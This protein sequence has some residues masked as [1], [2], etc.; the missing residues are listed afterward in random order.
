MRGWKA[1]PLWRDEISSLTLATQDTWRAFWDTLQFDPFPVLFPAVLRS[2]HALVGDSDFALRILGTSIGLA[3]IGA[4]WIVA[5]MT[6]RRPP[7][8]ALLLLGSSPTVIIWGDTLR[9]YGLS[10]FWI[11]ISF[12]C[13]WR[14]LAYPSRRTMIYATGASILSVQS[15]FTN[16]VLVFALVAAVSLIALRRRRWNSMIMAVGAGLL[17]AVS[18]LPYLPTILRIRQWSFLNQT[19]VVPATHLRIFLEAINGSGGLTIYLWLAALIAALTAGLW[20]TSAKSPERDTGD[21]GRDL[22]C[23]S[24]LVL[25]LGLITTFLFFL[26]T[27]WEPNVWYFLPVLSLVAVAIDTVASAGAPASRA[28]VMT[29]AV[30]IVAALGLLLP[31]I[32]GRL[33]ERVSNLDLVAGIVAREARPG[34]VILL[35]PFADGITFNRYYRG[36]EEWLT[37]P[38]LQDHSLHNWAEV[39]A[40]VKNPKVMDLVLSE[41]NRAL[42]GWQARLAGGEFVAGGAQHH[43]TECR[44]V[45]SEKCF[46]SGVVPALLVESSG[47]RLQGSRSPDQAIAGLV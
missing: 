26:Q 15:A 39:R 4:F 36:T 44:S 6:H 45:S 25:L 29:K 24:I 1:G 40:A 12:G 19:N 9:A 33:Q 2:W 11:V 23:F 41:V 27:Q 34:D 46:S 14:L 38:S 3:V 42:R 37:V 47:R 21:T 28:L 16:S 10:V 35:Y 7:L 22:V 30:S 17:A 8:V 20:L 43:A 18:L 5:R 13:F 32:W 31:A